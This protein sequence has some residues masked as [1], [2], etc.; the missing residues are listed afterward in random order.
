MY[1]ACNPVI[2]DDKTSRLIQI[3]NIRRRQSGYGLTY[4][5]CR[6]RKKRKHCGKRRKC[7]FPAFSPFLTMFF[8]CLLFHGALDRIFNEGGA[9]TFMDAQDKNNYIGLPL[10]ILV[11]QN[12]K[13]YMI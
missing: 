11:R 2:G 13:N 7:W 3:D 1:T 9:Y 8:L 5:I 10:S 12:P 6:R 4:E